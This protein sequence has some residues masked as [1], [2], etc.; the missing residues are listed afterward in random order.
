M[1]GLRFWGHS[2]FGSFCWGLG[3]KGVGLRFRRSGLY[4]E[5]SQVSA[6]LVFVIY[7]YIYYL[8]HLI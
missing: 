2:G 4:A 8:L 6:F 3:L 1:S 7:I 5:A